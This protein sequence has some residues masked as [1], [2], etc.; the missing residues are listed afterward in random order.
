MKGKLVFGAITFAA[1]IAI[2]FSYFFFNKTDTKASNTKIVVF[3]YQRSDNEYDKWNVWL[4]DKDGADIGDSNFTGV[5]DYGAYAVAECNAS[6]DKLGFKVRYST[7]DNSWDKCDIEEDR[8]LSLSSMPESTI[9]VYLKSGDK[10]FSAKGD[11]QQVIT[12]AEIYGPD[13]ILFEVSDVQRNSTDLRFMIRDKEGNQV[14]VKKVELKNDKKTGYIHLNK[15]LDLLGTYTLNNGVGSIVNVVMLD[16]YDTKEFEN[17]CIYSGN[18][19]GVTLANNSTK[20]RAWAPTAESLSVKLYKTGREDKNDLVKTYAMTKDIGGTWILNV[21]ENLTGYY[22]VYNI[23]YRESFQKYYAKK[24]NI[25]TD[26]PN[27]YDAVDPYARSAGENATKGMIIDVKTA[28]PE[29]W[30]RDTNHT[31][32]KITDAIIYETSVRD[33][34]SSNT[35]G[36][37]NKGKYVSFL[38]RGTKTAKGTPTGMDHIVNMGV[39]MVQLMP[40]FDFASVDESK[41]LTN[42]KYN[43]GY[44]PA[45]YNVPEGSFS[46]NAKDGTTRVY[47]LKQMIQA[48]HNEKIG[49]I[50]DVVYNHT[51]FDYPFGFAVLAPGYF[52][53]PNSNTSGCGNDVATERKMVTKYIVESIVYWAKEYHIDGFR[54]DLMG[55]IDLETMNK[56]RQELD[57]LNDE[58]ILYGEG[59]YMDSTN[60][61]RDVFLCNQNNCRLTDELGFFSDTI[62]N[63]LRGGNDKNSIGFLQ[64]DVGAT[65]TMAYSSKAYSIWSENEPYQTINYASCH[66]NYT[67]WD[68]LFVSNPKNTSEATLIAQNKLSAGIVLTSQGVPLMLQGEEFLRTKENDKGEKVENSYNAPDSV[69]TLDYSRLDKYKNVADYYKGL[70]LFRKNH[71][72]LRMLRKSQVDNNYRWLEGREV[73]APGVV[74]FELN[75]VQGEVADGI[76]VIYNQNKTSQ[77][78]RLPEGN[79]QVCVDEN[80]AGVTPLRTVSQNVQVA[81]MSCYILVKG[82]T[83]AY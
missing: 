2:V 32:K 44:D 20:F 25:E 11:N 15:D 31:V 68:K 1:I 35:S 17:E 33:T 61:T 82:Q 56:V 66:D 46:T 3:H 62:R 71:E 14:D 70:I 57:K 53:R 21:P 50:M 9:H 12:K 74:A 42:D 73:Y 78:V 79:W 64:G 23:K 43:W 18:D 30:S 27:G 5:D 75:K 52:H 51:Y 24:Y 6:I 13:K 67:L 45:N 55:L 8:F 34:S 65:K 59:W 63:G 37:K 47:E 26:S 76:V 58:I 29:G 40:I 4:W 7:I 60:R 54:F 22:Y 69:N 83:K 39:N 81:P 10:S 16:Y 28:S 41:P 38:E 49:V 36:I 48:F 72:A 19:L 77:T 80:N